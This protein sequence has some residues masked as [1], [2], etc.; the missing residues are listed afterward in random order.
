MENYELEKKGCEDGKC[1][2]VGYQKV[3]VSVPVTV[4]PF[5]KAGKAE[6]YCYG[7]AEVNHG[8]D[9]CKGIENGQCTFTI[10]QKL[11]VAIP[12]LFGAVAKEG[13]TYVDCKDC[14]YDDGKGPR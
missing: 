1:P 12:V 10:S 9:H 6:V 7:K 8:K 3:E 14:Y 5:A 4:T 2:A 11:L 13:G